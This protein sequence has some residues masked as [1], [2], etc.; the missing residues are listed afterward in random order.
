MKI[1]NSYIFN[2]RV[3]LSILNVCLSNDVFKVVL[4]RMKNISLQNI[5]TGEGPLLDNK[6]HSFA[7]KLLHLVFIILL[8]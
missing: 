3:F 1:F 7:D 5:Y 8:Y 4:K 6:I 2:V